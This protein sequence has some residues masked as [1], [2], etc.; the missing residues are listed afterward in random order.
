MT[1][2]E[3]FTR[4]PANPIIQAG[5]IPIPCKAV[6]NP[7]AYFINGETLLLLRV[8]D[9]D[10][11]SHLLAARS[12]DGVGE[13]HFDAS[14][15]LSPGPD[16]AWYETLGCEDPRIS[17]LADREEYLIAYVG[18]SQFGAG[19]CLASTT[20]FQTV[21]RLGMVIHPYNKDAAL[22]PRKVNGRYLLLHR[23]T[24]GPLE[25][26]WLGESDNL[27][28]WGNPQCVLQED[29]K[30]G[31]DSGKV[32]TGPPPIET[33]D[34]WLLIFH[35]VELIENNWEYRVG[36][37]LLDRDN[38]SKILARLPHWVL[39]PHAPYE[40]RGDMPGIIFPTGAIEQNGMLSLYYGAADTS[41]ALAT[42]KVS[43]LLQALRETGC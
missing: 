16:A 10:D 1:G 38:P 11:H 30:P 41:V 22:F 43:D 20:D 27:L 17:Y 4:H 5:D 14:P 31:W 19:V 3:L 8:I 42:A 13:W 7:A 24:A 25:D 32:G 36:L 34:G 35:G 29:D 2:P 12:V 26:V 6:C 40:L 18:A 21:S 37:A 33:P 23:P 28:H 39:E 15:L 9:P